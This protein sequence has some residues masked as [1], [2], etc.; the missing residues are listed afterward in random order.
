MNVER[1]E[2]LSL[3]GRDARLRADTQ[4]ASAWSTP[5][6][7]ILIGDFHYLETR[8]FLCICFVRDSAGR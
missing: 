6:E 1:F 4:C 8:E 2:A 7:A 3:W 5:D